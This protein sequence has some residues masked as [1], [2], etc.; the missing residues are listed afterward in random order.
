MLKGL[1]LWKGRSGRLKQFRTTFLGSNL[2]FG[3]YGAKILKMNICLSN[4]CSI[5]RTDASVPLGTHEKLLETVKDY[6]I[7]HREWM[8]IVKGNN[9]YARRNNWNINDHKWRVVVNCTLVLLLLCREDTASKFNIQY[10][11]NC[12]W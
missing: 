10:W 3:W 7:A 9:H 12:I 6:S 2:G 4:K 8:F 1:L 5:T 11:K